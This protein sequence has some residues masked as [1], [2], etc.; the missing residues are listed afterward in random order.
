M[1]PNLFKKMEEI[2]HS[3]SGG[4]ALWTNFSR[5]Q[6]CNFQDF[7]FHK[8]NVITT[9]LKEFYPT[10]VSWYVDTIWWQKAENDSAI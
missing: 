1:E 5:T 4:K 7:R 10:W 3:E 9:F 6:Y 8:V 2:I